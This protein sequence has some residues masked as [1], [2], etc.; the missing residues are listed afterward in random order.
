MLN[1]IIGWVSVIKIR[2]LGHGDVVVVTDLGLQ[3]CDTGFLGEMRIFYKS[4]VKDLEVIL[5][6]YELSMLKLNR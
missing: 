4:L 5:H 1:N 3:S 6:M 2:T